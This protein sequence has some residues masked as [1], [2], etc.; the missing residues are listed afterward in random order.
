MGKFKFPTPD[1]CK[2]KDRAV[3]CAPDRILEL[4]NQEPGHSQRQNVSK[5]VKVWFASQVP[6]HD[7]AGC[8]FLNDAVTAHAAGCVLFSPPQTVNVN[9]IVTE[10][11][12][13]LEAEDG[14]D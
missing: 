2:L 8:H 4:Y 13:V 12:L 9:M 3:L 5:K 7:W 11:M 1:K 10:T 6:K 14:N